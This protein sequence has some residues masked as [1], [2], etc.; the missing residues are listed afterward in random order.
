M[1]SE[2]YFQK[3]FLPDKPPGS[4]GRKSEQLNNMIQESVSSSTVRGSVS[5]YLCGLRLPRHR[6]ASGDHRPSSGSSRRPNEESWCVRGSDGIDGRS[7]AVF[8]DLY[9]TWLNTFK[10]F[11]LNYLRKNLS[12]NELF[13]RNIDHSTKKKKHSNNWDIFFAISTMNYIRYRMS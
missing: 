10:S 7:L 12:L 2:K 3:E 8:L 1:I 4:N 6:V 9:R 11:R 13:H 5:R